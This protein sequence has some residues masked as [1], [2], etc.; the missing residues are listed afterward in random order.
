MLYKM[1]YEFSNQSWFD[2]IGIYKLVTIHKDRFMPNFGTDCSWENV[3]TGE[4]SNNWNRVMRPLTNLEIRDF[5]LS[6]I[7]N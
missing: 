4:L 6:L 5:N 1:K 7:L 2:D 3:I